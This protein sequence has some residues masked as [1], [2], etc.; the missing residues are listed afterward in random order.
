MDEYKTPKRDA[1]GTRLAK[2]AGSGAL[3][4][5]VYSPGMTKPLGIAVGAGVGGLFAGAT[6]DEAKSAVRTVQQKAKLAAVVAKNAVF[7]APHNIAV[8]GAQAIGNAALNVT[9]TANPVTRAAVGGAA[10]IAPGTTALVGLKTLAGA[11]LPQIERSVGR[12]GKEVGTAAYNAANGFF[13]GV[14]KVEHAAGDMLQRA[15]GIRGVQDLAQRGV[16][17]LASKPKSAAETSKAFTS[18]NEGQNK[19]NMGRAPDE[20]SSAA[21]AKGAPSKTSS[22]GGSKGTYQTLDGRAVQGTPAQQAAW[23]ARRKTA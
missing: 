14:D 19:A 22:D 20:V 8:A 15:T 3:A 12:A 16:S 5:A 4:G 21:P 1:L 18:K 10:Y 9:E 17:A 2:G 13:K 11:S 23:S 7:N 6:S